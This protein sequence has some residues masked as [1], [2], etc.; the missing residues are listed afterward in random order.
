MTFQL[1]R[2]AIPILF[3]LSGFTGLVY[4]VLWLKELGHIFG[5]TAQA[6]AT[7]LA[8]FFLGL[9]AGGYWWGSRVGQLGNAL[10]TYAILEIGVSVSALLYFALNRLYRELYE[11]LYAAAGDSPALLAAAKILLSAAVLFP[12]SFLMGGTFPVMGQH[13]VRG[14]GRLGRDGSFL[15][16]INTAGAAGGAFAAGFYLPRLFGFRNSYLIAIALNLGIALVAWFL[17]RRSLPT[18][19]TA[20][21]SKRKPRAP[22]P[23]PLV[24]W[25]LAAS[26]G[27]LA[28]GLEVVW[29]RMF[30]QV[31]QNSVY[32]FSAIL[33]VF[34]TALGLGSVLANRLCLLRAHPRPVLG[35]LLALSGF[36]VALTPFAF[37]DVTAGLG[38]LGSGKGWVPYLVSVFTDTFLIVLIPGILIGSIFPYLLR[39]MQET[40]MGAGKA[41]GRLVALN[42]AGAV[43]GSLLTGFVLLSAFG[44]WGSM[45]LLAVAYFLLA[46]ITVQGSSRASGLLRVLP[47][48]GVLSLFTILDATRLPVI[49]L[50][51]D[52]SERLLQLWE[53][54]NGVVAAID[55][56]GS[57]SL[58]VNNHYR[59]GGSGAM[60]TEQNQTLIPLM[61]HPSPNEIFF[62][63]M[64]TGISAGAAMR[65]PATRVVVCELIP[66]V[67]E[68]GKLYFNGFAQGL[69][70]DPRTTLLAEDGRNRLAGDRRRYDAII[71][72]LFIPWRSGVGSLYSV[73]HFETAKSR[74]KP[75]GI[76]V[77]WLPLYQVSEAEFFTIARTMLH[78]FPHVVLW[79]GEFRPSRPL[80]AFIGSSGERVL[81]PAVIVDRGRYISGIATLPAEATLAVTLPFYIG[82]LSR[83][84]VI[85]PPGPVNT[86]DRPIIEYL[87]PMTN[88]QEKEGKTKWFRSVALAEFYDLLWQQTPPESDPYLARLSEAELGYVRAGL[89]YYKAAVYKD[90]GDMAEADRHMADFQSR[91]PVR[92]A[93]ETRPSDS[94]AEV[95][96]D[97]PE[98]IARESQN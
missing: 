86:D 96:E 29:T 67:I 15:Y 73:E 32:T 5:N 58:K 69:F 75:G 3:F 68:A 27:F 97:T 7:T 65:Q 95:T 44:I 63:G 85:V 46:L 79:R 55:R 38:Y 52:R 34:L 80:I 17:S 37:I 33:V 54:N 30:S 16:A 45:R 22:A 83:S 42:T 81:D 64:G 53:G 19:P 36:A 25:L 74:L 59:L 88:R 82:N 24:F 4:E 60:E 18:A 91:I 14:P 49:R 43:A 76:F 89:S 28:L 87:A 6:A 61:S 2:F 9:A 12:P 92:F 90:R 48:A 78:V 84:A 56:N 26:S 21:V 23:A 20:P 40:R 35:V 39:A 57:L 47:V 31:L 93:P 72:D 71:A 62:L 1:N 41:I 66:E 10:R 8:V 77:Q 11:P 50:R 70:T 98:A 94:E 51:A 13:L